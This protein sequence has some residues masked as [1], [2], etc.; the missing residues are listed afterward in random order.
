MGYL[1]RKCL[2]YRNLVYRSPRSQNDGL[3]ARR[4]IE[5]QNRPML[6]E[7]EFDLNQGLITITFSETVEAGSI[8]VTD[9]TFQSDLELVPANGSVFYNLT[10]GE[11]ISSDGPIIA[12]LLSDFDLN[13]IKL[14]RELAS[15]A[16]RIHS[17]LSDPLESETPMATLS[18]RSHRKMHCLPLP[19]YR[20]SPDRH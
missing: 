3:Q 9:F 14:D 10:G 8:T 13:E 11:V 1:L 2:V 20:I 12:I 15:G 5:D 17:S 19:S 6:L 4:V 16:D 18:L 7:F